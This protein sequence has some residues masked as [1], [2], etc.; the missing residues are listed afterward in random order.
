ML[1]GEKR[2]VVTRN[3]PLKAAALSEKM[4]VISGGEIFIYGSTVGV[5]ETPVIVETEHCNLGQY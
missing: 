1:K 4:K 2:N 3:Y 5:K